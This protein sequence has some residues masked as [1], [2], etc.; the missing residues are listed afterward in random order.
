MHDVVD[1][2][3]YAAARWH[4]VVSTLVLL[5]VPPGHAATLAREALVLLRAEW[6]HQDVFDDLDAE[7]YNEVLDRWRHDRVPWWTEPPLDGELW[8]ELEAELDRLTPAQREWLVL[9]HV[10]ELPEVYVADAVGEPEPTLPAGVPNGERLR[11]VART[12]PVPAPDLEQVVALAST[13][14]RRR[15]RRAFAG[16]AGLV[17]VA[18]GISLLIA[19]T[20]IDEPGGPVV[21]QL[22][23]VPV[24]RFAT[25][26][27]V[28]WYAEGR[29][30]L[31]QVVLDLPG[32]RDLASINNGAVYTDAEGDLVFVN[33]QG[34][35]T[36]LASIGEDGTFVASDEDGLL[37][38]VPAGKDVALVVR[39]LTDGSDV[40]RVDVRGAG[41]VIAIDN[42]NVFLRDDR[43]DVEISLETGDA[44]PLGTTSLI[45]VSARA[46]VFQ[47]TP[48]IIRVV[49]PLFD[50]EFTWPGEG[51]QL[52][53]DGSYVL[54]RVGEDIVIHDTRNGEQ[55][56]SDIAPGERALDA[57]LGLDPTVT[58]LVIE[59]SAFSGMVALRT[60]SLVLI[61][62]ESGAREPRCS[63]EAAG[64]YR[65]AETDLLLAR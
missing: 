46:S 27:A 4:P 14:A 52:S 44:E 51:A 25:G 26:S 11:D 62:P 45:D 48:S 35:R 20:A 21:E 41:E 12:I 10:A 13:R 39:D 53:E 37:A 18:G 28:P 30:H 56:P 42:R 63:Q 5:G 9:R 43:G 65:G 47:A 29:L 3:S 23:P 33:D 38:W 34:E 24:S 58:Y 54:T 16:A 2:E 64:T 17:V 32:V 19:T 6:S 40:V 15:R 49:H 55:L 31:S 36:Q 60:C 7:L 8:S 50:N 57:E 61:I 22:D 1:F 59:P